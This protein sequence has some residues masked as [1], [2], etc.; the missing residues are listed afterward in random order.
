[1]ETQDHSG[2]THPDQGT[3]N[4]DLDLHL[5]GSTQKERK[6]EEEGGGRERGDGEKEGSVR[7]L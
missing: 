7:R 6:E 5:P 3:P 2:R 1:M 4:R